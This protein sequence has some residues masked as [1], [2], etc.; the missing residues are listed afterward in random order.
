MELD[1]LNYVLGKGTAVQMLS[2]Y[3]E[4]YCTQSQTDPG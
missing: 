2:N 4:D 1:Y 3:N